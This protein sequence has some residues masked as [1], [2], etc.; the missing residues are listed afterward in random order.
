MGLV[1]K[2]KEIMFVPL[3]RKYARY[4]EITGY[5]CIFTDVLTEE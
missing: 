1:V 3:R 5:C 2:N 4:C